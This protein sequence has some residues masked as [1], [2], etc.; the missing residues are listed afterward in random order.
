MTSN[1]LNSHM[2]KIKIATGIW[3]Q[4]DNKPGNLEHAFNR[5]KDKMISERENKEKDFVNFGN[6]LKIMFNFFLW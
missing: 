2:V 3:G 5:T 4:S 1:S 6:V